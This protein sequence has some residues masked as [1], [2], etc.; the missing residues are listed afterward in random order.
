MDEALARALELEDDFENLYVSK[1]NYTDIDHDTESIVGETSAMG[2]SRNLRE[3]DIDPDRMSYEEL[4][5][6][7][8]S[9]GNE[10]RGLSECLISQL[11]T[12]KFKSAS[13]NKNQEKEEC[14]ICCAEYKTGAG[15][16]T[17]P[18]A[19]H[20]HSDCINRWL[21]MNKHCP[22]CQKEVFEE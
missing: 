8:E 17:L 3:N 20:Y 10:S 6:L 21:G 2:E 22:V 16:T 12:F 9:V 4:Q 11:P 5:D 18:C 13:K 14:V 19:H 7:G 1:H 15:L